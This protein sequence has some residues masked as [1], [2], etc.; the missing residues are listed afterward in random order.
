M[1]Q[2]LAG[3]TRNTGGALDG[4]QMSTRAI[5]TG[6]LTRSQCRVEAGNHIKK[7][8]R[9]ANRILTIQLLHTS[10]MACLRPFKGLPKDVRQ[11]RF[12]KSGFSSGNTEMCLRRTKQ[13][14]P[15]R[16]LAHLELTNLPGHEIFI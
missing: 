15:S 6:R 5:G 8:S 9:S 2:P 10:L 12:V 11:V 1:A 14:F 13:K 7:T 3:V 4:N 16:N